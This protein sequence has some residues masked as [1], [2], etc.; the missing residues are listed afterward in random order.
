MDGVTPTFLAFAESPALLGHVYLKH[1]RERE[2][3]VDERI[4][5]K[6]MIRD[7]DA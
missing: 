4:Q 3:E 5:F 6:A 7:S 2:R 1:G